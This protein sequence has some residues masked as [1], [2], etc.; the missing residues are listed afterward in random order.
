MLTSIINLILVLIVIIGVIAIGYLIY[1]IIVLSKSRKS[2]ALYPV[3]KEMP[4]ITT[5]FLEPESEVSIVNESDYNET[6]IDPRAQAAI[7]RLDFLKI[8]MR[9]SERIEFLNKKTTDIGRDHDEDIFVED[10]SVSRCHATLS[11]ENSVLFITDHSQYG[12]FLNGERIVLMVPTP[13]PSGSVVTMGNTS[14]S[15]EV[16]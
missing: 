1:Q 11:V 15:I 9:P 8:A 16:F 10:P 7:A 3:A 12:T 13:V 6:T 5:S 4:E 14:F 2:K